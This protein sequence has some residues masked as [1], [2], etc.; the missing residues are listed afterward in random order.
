MRI[1]VIVRLPPFD[2]GDGNVIH[3]EPPPGPLVPGA[4]PDLAGHPGREREDT[5]FAEIVCQQVFIKIV[6]VDGVLGARGG[7]VCGWT[8]LKDLNSGSRV[9]HGQEIYLSEPSI[10]R[11][12]DRNR[13]D[14]SSRLL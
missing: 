8:V 11:A 12:P 5:D 6:R 1:N 2:L 3:P 13:S 7:R 14:P 9:W 4:E 10:Y